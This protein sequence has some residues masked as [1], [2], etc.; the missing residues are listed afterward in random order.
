MIICPYCGYENCNG[1][2]SYDGFCLRCGGNLDEYL[3]EKSL[4]DHTE[5]KEEEVK[6]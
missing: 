6:H 4:E 5:D 2:P 3:R 1:C